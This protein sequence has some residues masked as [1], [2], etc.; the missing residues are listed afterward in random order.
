MYSWNVFLE[1][2]PFTHICS[3]EKRKCWVCRNKF[4]FF[5]LPRVTSNHYIW[6]GRGSKK[7]NV[8]RDLGCIGNVLSLR[9]YNSLRREIVVEFKVNYHWIM[10]MWI[11]LQNDNSR[12][13]KFFSSFF[14]VDLHTKKHS[15]RCEHFPVFSHPSHPTHYTPNANPHHTLFFSTIEIEE[16]TSNIF[17]RRATEKKRKKKLGK[18]SNLA[19]FFCILLHMTFLLFYLISFRSKKLHQAPPFST[20]H[21]HFWR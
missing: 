20:Q 13:M 5:D 8:K 7:K 4:L 2:F 3:N 17:P 11:E 21:L 9:K 18:E 19:T 12:A 6:E 14:C 1:S 16:D 10:N 15:F